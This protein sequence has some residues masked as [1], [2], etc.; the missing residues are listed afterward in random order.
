MCRETDPGSTAIHPAYVNDSQSTG[1]TVA[2]GVGL[3]DGASATP[4]LNV[5]V[6]GGNASVQQFY[7]YSDSTGDTYLA[8]SLIHICPEIDRL[9]PLPTSQPN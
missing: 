7:T 2:S 8:L 6:L 4:G 9:S 1:V 3:T 5:Q